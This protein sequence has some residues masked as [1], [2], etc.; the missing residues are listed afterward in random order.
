MAEK[1]VLA[2]YEVGT[3]P[4]RGI[5]VSPEL[6]RFITLCIYKNVC[7]NNVPI[8]QINETKIETSEC[9]KNKIAGHSDNCF[10]KPLLQWEKRNHSVQFSLCTPQKNFLDS[11]HWR[12]VFSLHTRE[13][14]P[15]WHVILF[16]VHCL[17]YFF[18]Y[19]ALLPA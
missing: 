7:Q 6:H 8:F 9:T 13:E 2:I 5:C 15:T 12:R 4:I 16:T 11:A 19:T 1:L 14:L 10:K 18:I 17:R 3:C